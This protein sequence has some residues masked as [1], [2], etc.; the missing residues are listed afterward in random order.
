MKHQNVIQEGEDKNILVPTALDEM[1]SLIEELFENNNE[2]IQ[3]LKETTK[4]LEQWISPR[5]ASFSEKIGTL[6]LLGSEGEVN[7]IFQYLL[8]KLNL[9]MVLKK[10]FFSIMIGMTDL[11]V[12]STWG[13]IIMMNL[14]KKICLIQ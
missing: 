3:E 13:H 10:L 7:L 5:L 14:T 8:I 12:D 6:F 4:Q 1:I 9:Q 11:N 2:A